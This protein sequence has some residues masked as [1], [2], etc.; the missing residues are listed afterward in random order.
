MVGRS[1]VQDAEIAR[2]KEQVEELSRENESYRQEVEALR[3]SSHRRHHSSSGNLSDGY[4]TSSSGGTTPEHNPLEAGYLS[5]GSTGE[6]QDSRA[7]T[8]AA[9]K[10]IRDSALD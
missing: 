6:W 9:G 3:T 8:V 2:L 1:W 10:S 5:D 7:Y 4:T